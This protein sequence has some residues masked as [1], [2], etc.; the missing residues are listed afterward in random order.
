[1]S[2][3]H[4]DFLAI[5]ARLIE[6]RRIIQ[7]SGHVPG[8]FID[9]TGNFALRRPGTASLLERTRATV[10]CA[11]AIPVGVVMIDVPR[12]LES[13]ARRA[14]IDIAFVIKAEVGSRE[15]AIITL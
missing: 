11:G 6:G 5:A 15:G 1:M 12:C 8:I 9:I 13:L 4:L 10:L 2:K 7:G 3:Q 14:D